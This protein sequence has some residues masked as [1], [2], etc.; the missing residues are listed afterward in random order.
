MIQASNEN[1]GFVGR[2]MGEET[3]PLVRAVDMGKRYGEFVALH[4]LN[5]EVYSGEFF[6][7][8]GPCLL[9][10]SPSPRDLSTSRMPS[11]A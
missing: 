1:L 7:V 10:T 4:P 11:S 5:V 6:G 3:Q 8:F 9:Y 2:A